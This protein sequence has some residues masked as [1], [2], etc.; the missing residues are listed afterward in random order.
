MTSLSINSSIGYISTARPA[1]W[2][3]TPS[4]SPNTLQI[5]KPKVVRRVDPRGH[6]APQVTILTALKTPLLNLL[7]EPH[8]HLRIPT[9]LLVYHLCKRLVILRLNSL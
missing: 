3:I 4:A 9:H 1:P 7:P 6:P 2:L 8:N 5:P